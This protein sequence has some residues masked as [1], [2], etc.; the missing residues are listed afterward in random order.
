MID[1]RLLGL[2]DKAFDYRGYVTVRRRDGSSVVGYVYNRDPSHLDLLDEKASARLSVPLEEIADIDFSGEDAAAKSQE[3]W[4]RRKGKLEPRETS[5][6]GDWHDSGPVLVVVAL[7]VELRAVAR[8]LEAKPRDRRAQARVPGGEIVIRAI[9]VGGGS[10]A[11]VRQ[12]RPRLVVSCGFSGA[13]DARLAAGDL[14]L[15]T[16][17]RDDTGDLIAASEPARKAAAAA[18]RG[19]SLVEGEIGCVTSL[20]ATPEEKRALSRP[21]MLAIDMES[22][23]AARAASELG[24]PWIGVRVI[25]DGADVALPAFTRD[26][27]EGYVLGALKYALTGPH[28]VMELVQLSSAARRASD[29]LEEAM[30]RLA[31][32]LVRSEART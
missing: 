13:L 31:S 5:A 28:A 29:A 11:V 2:I 10:R 12:E 21:G 30:R 15:A 25:V 24:I 19:M 23:P 20:A 17:V 6:W 18:L 4:E 16:S 1:A 8:A 14:V 3:I 26:S 22:H 32:A 9:G 7:D 27:D